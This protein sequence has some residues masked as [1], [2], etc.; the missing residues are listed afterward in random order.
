MHYLT[1]ATCIKSEDHYIDNFIKIHE[2]LGAEAFIFFDRDGDNLT[3]KFKGRDDITVVKW[4]EP[5]RH[6]E[7]H[8]YVVKNFQGF[9]KWIAFIDCDQVLFSPTN[10]DVRITLQEYE[11]HAQVQVC[12]ETFGS[13]GHLIKEPGSVYER[14][15]R[16]ARSDAGINNHTQSVADIS[17]V[18]PIVPPDPHRL[19][20][21]NGFPSVDEN[22]KDIG[23]TPHIS[24]HTQNKLCVFHYYTK[25]KEEWD[26]KNNKGRSDIPGS[27][28]HYGIFDDCNSYCNE[29]EDT[30][31][32]D[33]WKKH[34]K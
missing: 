34:C 28:I 15:T 8:A 32:K 26:F 33:F 13:S 9:S 12:W 4:P 1:I 29:I 5:L 22:H 19:V 16:R 2:K 14:F 20:P 23:N 7:S 24:P 17:R 31:V 18:Q 27:K 10:E 6:H 3:D 21:I 30:R 11:Q 25:S